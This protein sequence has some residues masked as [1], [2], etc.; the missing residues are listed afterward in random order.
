MWK[1]FNLFY[2]HCLTWPINSIIFN[3]WSWEYVFT[4][5]L[6]FRTC[7]IML[8]LLVYFR[9]HMWIATILFDVN[10]YCR[11]FSNIKLINWIISD[12]L[13]HKGF[14]NRKFSLVVHMLLDFFMCL[15][16]LRGRTYGFPMFTNPCKTFVFA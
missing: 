15:V 14:K 7:L 9:D 6:T 4:S 3:K 5:L 11:F 1:N 2:H 13:V 8:C 10:M 12:P 16:L